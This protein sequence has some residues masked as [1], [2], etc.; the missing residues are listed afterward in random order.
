MIVVVRNG[1][2]R[3]CNEKKPLATE[4]VMQKGGS[5]R[6]PVYIPVVVFS[7]GLLKSWAVVF[8]L[9]KSVFFF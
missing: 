9:S 5:K 1:E 6:T 4:Q 2:K 3:P 7:I 8:F